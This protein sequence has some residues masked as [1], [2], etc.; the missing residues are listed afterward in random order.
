MISGIREKKDEPYHD[1]QCP[2]CGALLIVSSYAGCPE[3]GAWM[4][5]CPKC[6]KPFE[7]VAQATIEYYTCGMLGYLEVD[8][9]DKPKC[10]R[11]A[12]CPWEFNPTAGAYGKV[13]ETWVEGSKCIYETDCPRKHWSM[14]EWEKNKKKKEDK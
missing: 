3:E 12:L 9:K 1:T 14:E 8:T 5:D 11:E 13:G 2:Y 7:L 4:E 6:E 10:T